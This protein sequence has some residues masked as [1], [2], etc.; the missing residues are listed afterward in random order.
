[1]SDHQKPTTAKPDAA[2][3]KPAPEAKPFTE[4]TATSAPSPSNSTSL[5]TEWPKYLTALGGMIAAV[6]AL[7][8][9]LNGI[10]VFRAPVAPTLPAIP[11]PSPSLTATREKPTMTAVP[12]AAVAFTIIPSV[13]T[14]TPLP[15]GLLL[16]DD[17]SDPASGWDTE[18]SPQVD[19]GYENGEYRISVF[20]D[21]YAAWANLLQ[22]HDWKN[23]A[24][25]VDVRLV[26]GL[27]DN[28]IGI[29]ARYDHENENFYLFSVTSDGQYMVEM[30]KDDAW[31]TMVERAGSPALRKGKAVN[32]LRLECQGQTM[33]FYGNGELLVN[34]QDSTFAS[35]GVGLLVSALG[36]PPVVAAFDNIRVRSLD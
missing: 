21:E 11:S 28:Q 33:R 20:K 25:D 27:V 10:G 34:V 14:L 6:A 5:A 24:I 17:F 1:M 15:P 23:V 16:T 4:P 30:R 35:G 3:R 8:T 19:R 9:A 36:K 31:T 12:T 13:P 29:V 2:E 32:H 7:L 18:V 22:V 26:D